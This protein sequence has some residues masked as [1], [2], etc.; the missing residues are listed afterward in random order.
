VQWFQQQL[1]E[2]FAEEIHQQ[3][4]QRHDCLDVHVDYISWSL[5]HRL[6]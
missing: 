6:E 3:V 2:F 4:L 5:L 1:R